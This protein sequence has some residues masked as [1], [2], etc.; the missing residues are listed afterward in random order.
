MPRNNMVTRITAALALVGVL[1]GGIWAVDGR[2]AKAGEVQ[3]L[4]KETKEQ[5]TDLKADTLENRRQAIKR[6]VFDL[7]RLKAQRQLSPEE[8]QYLQEMKDDVDSLTD[9]LRAIRKR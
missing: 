8:Q 2:Y 6:T 5:I 3:Q 1:G 9:Q 4:R 7:E